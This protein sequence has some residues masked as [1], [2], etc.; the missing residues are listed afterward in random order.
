V[1]IQVFF[2]CLIACLFSFSLSFA[3]TLSQPE[4]AENSVLLK[5]VAL[6]LN[7]H[8]TETDTPEAAADSLPSTEPQSKAKPSGTPAGR[9]KPGVGSPAVATPYTF[10]TSGEMNRFWLKNSL[11][12]KA[13]IG[14]AFTA[15]WNQWV[16][17]SPKEWSKDATGWSQRFGS[18]LLD[19]AINT[20][21]LV[22]LSRASGQDPRY[23]RCDCTGVGPRTGHAILLAFTAYNRNGDLKFS[24]AKIVAP[25]TG[26]LVT[27][28]VV[29]PDSFGT[30]N[31]FSGWGYYLAGGV[32]W[33]IVREFFFKGW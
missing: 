23:R 6:L 25:V 4:G 11:G 12:P 28:N 16:I 3:Q 17:D 9:A 21:S 19:N 27:R 31:A 2:G 30:S 14:A 22:W 32:A 18:S 29:Y 8:T 24:P 26:P 13:A 20:T 15:S 1:R 10:P 7:P 33:N 5:P